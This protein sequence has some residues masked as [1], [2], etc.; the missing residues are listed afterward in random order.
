M[1]EEHAA[2][3]VAGESE[4]VERLSVEHVSF[5][6][7]YRFGR[8]RRIPFRERLALVRIDELDVLCPEVTDDLGAYC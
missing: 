5:W 3:A 8:P 7:R 2:A 1:G 6:F 4:F